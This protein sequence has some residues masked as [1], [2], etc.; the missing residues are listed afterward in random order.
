MYYLLQ[1]TEAEEEAP[2]LSHQPTMAR[3]GHIE[4]EP[5][6][7]KLAVC[8]DNISAEGL[9]YLAYLLV[10]TELHR[11]GC[12]TLHAAAASIG[13][14]ATLLL[15]SAGSGKTTTLLR[16]CRDHRASLIGNDLVVVGGTG[17]LPVAIA[18]SQHVRLRYSSLAS[19]MP[20]LLGLFPGEPIDTWRAKRN[21]DPSGL[22]ITMSAEKQV[23]VVV[24]IHVD[25]DCSQVIDEPGDTLIHRLNLY[26][27]ALRYIRGTSTPWL[28]NGTFGPY[29]PSLD[30]PDLHATRSVTLERLMSESRYISGPPAAVASHVAKILNDNTVFKGEMN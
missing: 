18:G 10:E 24:F 8:G 3:E 28:V 12:I 25:A 21:L 13:C 7:R 1:G 29:V 30:H 4:W 27:N 19:A 20:D 11:Q 23:T 22:G 17:S 5:V 16:L 9:L 6:E 2:M 15:G 26:E 14:N